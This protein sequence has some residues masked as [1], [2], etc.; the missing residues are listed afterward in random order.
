M[1]SHEQIVVSDESSSESSNYFKVF[2]NKRIRKPSGKSGEKSDSPYE[3]FNV[4]AP[5]AHKQRTSL[6]L[7]FFTR[8]FA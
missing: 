4:F 2:N 8:K 1:D 6:I 5:R 3:F 7:S